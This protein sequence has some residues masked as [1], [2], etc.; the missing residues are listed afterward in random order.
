MVDGGVSI[1]ARSVY[2][3]KQAR[4]LFSEVLGDAEKRA[5]KKSCPKHNGVGHE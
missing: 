3:G 5:G 2:P 1:A 4:L